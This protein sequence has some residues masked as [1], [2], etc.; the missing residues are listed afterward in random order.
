MVNIHCVMK[1]Y[2]TLFIFL[3]LVIDLG[4]Q[5]IRKNYQEMSQ[6]EKVQLVNAFYALRSGPDLIN[7]LATFH[8]NNFNFDNTANPN[9]FD[10]HFNLGDTQEEANRDIFLAWHRRQMFEVEQAI[11]NINPRISLVFWDS[12]VDQSI[13]SPLWDEDLMGSFDDNWGLVRNLGS[14]G[15]L[16]TPSV[17]TNLQNTPGN[18]GG[19]FPPPLTGT[20]GFYVYSNRFERGDVHRGAHVWTGGVMPT[21][22]SPRDPIFYLHH[23][24]VDRLWQEWEERNPGSSGFVRTSML[25]YDGTY[26]FNG[27]TL[28]SVNPNSLIDSRVLGVFYAT[29]QLAI[30]DNYIVSNTYK[31]EEVFYYQYVIEAGEDGFIVPPNRAAR[32]ESLNSVVL[33]P[34]FFAQSGARFTARIDLANS[35]NSAKSFDV[36]VDN[37]KPFENVKVFKDIVW[38]EN[39][40]DDTPIFMTTFPNPFTNKITIKLNKRTDCSIEVFNMM[41]MSIRKE[42]FENTDTLEINNL[43]GLASGLYVIQVL[44]GQGEILL[45][46]R[47]VK[48]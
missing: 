38:E 39:D 18:P 22:V 16:P 19:I 12:S 29:N 47:V 33:K 36:L 32:M 5:S 6:Y 9:R 2:F 31:P 1:K 4:A 37:Q 11:Q 48:L 7:D 44:N 27:Q 23:S 15:P 14:N 45:A 25:R 13:I 20:S 42:S 21:G 24:N 26:V 46:K 17:V 8:N 35:G 43:Y 10:L 41:G 3:S 40:K 28:P 30:L 34:G